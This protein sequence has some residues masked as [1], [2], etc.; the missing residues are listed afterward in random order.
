MSG[1]T[2]SQPSMCSQNQAGPSGS[3]EAETSQSISPSRAVMVV[4]EGI[5]AGQW[6]DKERD[7]MNIQ[8]VSQT[9]C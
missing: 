3:T 8:L 2:A 1:V 5:C 7:E 6:R 9:G 4:V